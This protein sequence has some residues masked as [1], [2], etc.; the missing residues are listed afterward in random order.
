MPLSKFRG[1]RIHGDGVHRASRTS[2]HRLTDLHVSDDDCI[3]GK[4][5]S[6]HQEEIYTGC[7]DGQVSL[8]RTIFNSFGFAGGEVVTILEDSG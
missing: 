5:P 8:W 6:R 4:I 1:V 3:M 7:D 2:S